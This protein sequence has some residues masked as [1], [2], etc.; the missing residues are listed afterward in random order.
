M[1]MSPLNVS[2]VM[3]AAPA[4]MENVKLFDV[5]EPTEENREQP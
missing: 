4:P 1:V 3:R 2:A 5:A